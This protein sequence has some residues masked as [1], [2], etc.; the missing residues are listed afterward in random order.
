MSKLIRLKCYGCG[1]SV[2]FAPL[3]GRNML[4]EPDPDGLYVLTE[5]G[6]RFQ[7]DEWDDVLHAHEKR[8]RPHKE[9]CIAKALFARG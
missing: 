7:V 6:G 5:I 3:N 4:A 9:T 1:K 8:Y 2:I